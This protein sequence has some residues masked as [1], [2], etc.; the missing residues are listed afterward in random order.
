MFPGIRTT[1]LTEFQDYAILCYD[2]FT[3]GKFVRG[4]EI[5]SLLRKH[6]ARQVEITLVVDG[7]EASLG[8]IYKHSLKEDFRSVS[9]GLWSQRGCRTWLQNPEPHASFAHLWLSS[10]EYFE[11]D[12]QTWHGYITYF[13]LQNLESD[14]AHHHT[15]RTFMKR[16][17]AGL[18]HSRDFSL[19]VSN[20]ETLFLRGNGYDVPKITLSPSEFQCLSKTIDNESLL[21]RSVKLSSNLPYCQNAVSEPHSPDSP[22]EHMLDDGDPCI[23]LILSPDLHASLYR[24]YMGLRYHA[25]ALSESTEVFLFGAYSRG[26]DKHPRVPYFSE[27]ALNLVSGDYTVIRVTNL[28]GR[29]LFIRVL[30][31][32][33]AFGVS[34]V[35]PMINTS[36]PEIESTTSLRTTADTSKRILAGEIIIHLRLFLPSRSERAERPEQVTEVLKVIVSSKPFNNQQAL[37]L[38]SMRDEDYLMNQPNPASSSISNRGMD[39]RMSNGIDARRIKPDLGESQAGFLEDIHLTATFTRSSYTIKYVLHRDEKSFSRPQ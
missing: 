31:F 18:R 8:H 13:L 29:P 4:L 16:L 12:S 17:G 39:N 19:V 32:D 33:S 10:T 15:Y 36:T 9:H 26:G 30:C 2:S 23:Q 6:V 1:P 14:T 3:D 28:L 37:E 20:M 5:A 22:T 7:R 35:Y 24:H 27:G 11:P 34:Q 21:K 25:R 38:P